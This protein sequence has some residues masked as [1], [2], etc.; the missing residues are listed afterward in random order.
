[1]K[2]EVMDEEYHRD[3]GLCFTR[4]C[5]LCCELY[6]ARTEGET[7]ER[8]IIEAENKIGEAREELIRWSELLARTKTADMA[9]LAKLTETYILSGE[10]P[11]NER[12]YDPLDIEPEGTPIYMKHSKS[13]NDDMGHGDPKA[14]ATPM[15]KWK[16]KDMSGHEYPPEAGDDGEGRY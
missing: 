8:N 9:K 7:I 10:Q 15:P 5:S 6:N 3:V 13:M 2:R 16:S 14:K 4:D 12:E 11:T 1:M